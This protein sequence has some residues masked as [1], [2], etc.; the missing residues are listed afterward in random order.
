MRIPL[1]GRQAVPVLALLAALVS[2]AGCER[3]FT[4]ERFDRIERGVDDREDVRQLLG[5]PTAAMEDAWIYEDLDHHDTAQI[6]FA[7][8]GRVLSKEWMDARTGAWEGRSPYTD[9]PRTGEVRERRTRTRRIDD[10]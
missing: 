3:K 8:D 7:D 9:E 10:D 4:R 5:R 1:C 6:F 2:L